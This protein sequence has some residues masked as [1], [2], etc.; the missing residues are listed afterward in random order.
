MIPALCHYSGIHRIS[1]D[2]RA[3]T[4]RR[5]GYTLSTITQRVTHPPP[6]PTHSITKRS[7]ALG[8][9]KKR[10]PMKQ[11]KLKKSKDDMAEIMEGWELVNTDNIPTDTRSVGPKPLKIKQ[12]G[13]RT[14]KDDEFN[15]MFDEAGLFKP[16]KEEI[17]A[18]YKPL[19]YAWEDYPDELVKGGPNA[20][21]PITPTPSIPT[22]PTPIVKTKSDAI[23]MDTILS[24]GM[25]M[26]QPRPA[27]KVVEAE[28]QVADVEIDDAMM[29]SESGFGR[30]REMPKRP[31]PTPPAVQQTSSEVAPIEPKKSKLAKPGTK[32]KSIGSIKES[33]TLALPG[34]K[35]VKKFKPKTI[36]DVLLQPSDEAFAEAADAMEMAHRPTYLREKDHIEKAPGVP[37][38]AAELAELKKE[39]EALVILGEGDD[40]EDDLRI[41]RKTGLIELKKKKAKLAKQGAK[42]QF[43][44]KST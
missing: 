41:N 1:H 3:S 13:K 30:K 5:R 20:T 43:T 2:G 17:M 18:T 23:S 40:H 11:P 21:A 10:K 9:G 29:F 27:K 6:S 26:T 4:F 44:G 33:G 42:L 19:R 16:A 15:A 14:S 32:K 39:S 37:Y 31:E 12:M 8:G 24:V 36:A 34:E 25:K 22:M 28:V 7:Y 38:T 35:T